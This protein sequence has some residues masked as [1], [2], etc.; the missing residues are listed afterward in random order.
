MRG[1]GLL[2]VGVLGT[3][4]LPAGAQTAHYWTN[5]FGNRAR[6]LGGAVVGSVSDLSAVY[7]NP[8]AL[9]LLDE[10]QFLLG[11]NV[12]QFTSLSVRDGLDEGKDLDTSRLVGV[13]PLFAGRLRLGFLGN[14]HRLAYAFLTRQNVDLRLEE[15][16]QTQGAE[17]FGLPGV[18]F[19]SSDVTLEQALGEY[20]AGATWAYPLTEY[21]GIGVSPFLAVRGQTV[22]QQLLL[23]G[24][25]EGGQA[26]LAL[27]SR[28]FN[29][30]HARLLAKVGVAAYL[31]D[32]RFGASLTTPSLGIWG[33]GASGLDSTLVSQGAAPTQVATDFQEGVRATYRSPLS[34]GLGA[35]RAFGDTRVHVAA[36]WFGPVPEYRVLDTQPFTAQTSGE[37]LSSDVRLGLGSVLNVGVGL[38]QHYSEDLDLYLSFRTD[39]SAATRGE[40]VSAAV[41]A[42]DLYHFAAGAS[43]QVGRSDFTLGAIFAAGDTTT[44]RALEF[45]PEDGLGGQLGLRGGSRVE[46]YRL[47][48][49]LG[50]GFLRAL[51]DAPPAPGKAALAPR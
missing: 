18:R 7:Y 11:G 40:D 46:Y 10:P 24:L 8:G 3:L 49:V 30:R 47:S 48:L 29:Y 1:V 31:G 2:L 23:Q 9:A 34:V 51:A 15:R 38:E 39:F 4:P 28:E 27:R 22:R 33:R 41:S 17:V 35:S 45:V 21:V 14:K 16:A 6:L 44:R 50:V 19:S 36:E 5:Q 13:A 12:Y 43:F 37:E 26:G 25:G 32:W 42:W 20:W